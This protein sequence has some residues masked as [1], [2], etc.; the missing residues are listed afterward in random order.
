MQARRRS[1]VL[2]DVRRF[3]SRGQLLHIFCLLSSHSDGQQ[4]RSNNQ[5]RSRSKNTNAPEETSG[6][7]RGLHL[8]S[9]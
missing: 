7:I 2:G 4:Q 3:R 8:S 1:H 6:E 9:A 5:S